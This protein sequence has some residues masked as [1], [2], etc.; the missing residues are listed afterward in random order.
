MKHEHENMNQKAELARF[1]PMQV[2]TPRRSVKK[3]IKN[4]AF[5]NIAI[6]RHYWMSTNSIFKILCVLFHI[7]MLA[8]Y[9]YITVR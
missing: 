1:L 7:F 3:T 9:L 8:F 6:A 5:P 2:K 4:C